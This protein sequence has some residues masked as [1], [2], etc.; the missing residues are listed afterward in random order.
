MT[1]LILEIKN[2]R[3]LAVLFSF[4]KLLDV[5]VIRKEATPPIEEKSDIAAFYQKHLLDLSNFKF[6]R[7]EAHER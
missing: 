1:R 5:R 2:N 6:N 4:L 7:E 3:D